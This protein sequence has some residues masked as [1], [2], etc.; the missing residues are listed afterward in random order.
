M[1]PPATRL[2][3][4]KAIFDHGASFLLAEVM[5]RKQVDADPALLKVLQFPG[6]VLNAFA[7][8]LFLKCLLA[9]DGKGEQRGHNLRTLYDKLSDDTKVKIKEEWAR[10]LAAIGERQLVEQGQKFGV[11]F[12]RDIETSLAECGEAFVDMRYVYENP[13]GATFYITHL[14]LVLKKVIEQLTGWK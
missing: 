2:A 4:A 12:A 7:S 5:L 9:L 6:M 10:M 14:P 3:K 8:E 13:R 11:T 1:P